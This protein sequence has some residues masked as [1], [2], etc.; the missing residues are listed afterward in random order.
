MSVNLRAIIFDF[1]GVIIDDEPLHLELFRRVLTEEG[2]TLSDAEYH[3]KYLGCDDRG[4]FTLAL[5]DAGLINHAA[6]TEFIKDL[7]ARKADYYQESIRDRFE[8]IPGAVDLIRRSA[9]SHP[10][11]LVSG[12][13]RNE[14][15]V[16]LGRGGI[17]EFFEVVVASEDVDACKPD[18]EGYLR[19]LIELNRS[20]Q[21]DS[22]LKAI[23]CLVIED[24]VAGVEAAK[25]AG[26]LCLA[27]TGSYRAD[28][29]HQADWVVSSLIG[30]DPMS[31]RDPSEHP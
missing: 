17:R 9:G 11:A 6:D 12:A 16:V 24:S 19:A 14:I 29:L 4:C 2:L 26:M 3:A 22:S 31:L 8:F 23:E 27:L 21:F 5:R 18:P 1:N 30:L 13:L 10:L 25:R 28:E 20:G 7:I 15:E